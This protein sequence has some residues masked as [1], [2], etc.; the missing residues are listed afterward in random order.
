[1]EKSLNSL[2]NSSMLLVSRYRCCVFLCVATPCCDD[3]SE[4]IG[5]GCST[6]VISVSLVFSSVL[7]G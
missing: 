6:T 7:P 1:M 2:A 3:V 4:K 5:V